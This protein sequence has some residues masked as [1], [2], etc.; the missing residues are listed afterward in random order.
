MA[1]Q[2]E[3]WAFS[4]SRLAFNTGKPGRAKSLVIKVRHG[5]KNSKESIGPF[6]LALVV[7]ECFEK[8][9]DK[10]LDE[11][12]FKNTPRATSVQTF[13]REIHAH[14]DTRE[15][16]YIARL[17][18]DEN[19]RIRYFTLKNK[20]N[21]L[22]E[23]KPLS[24]MNR[25]FKK[26]MFYSEFV[27]GERQSTRKIQRGHIRDT[28]TKLLKESSKI[29]RN[30]IPSS[31][32]DI[33]LLQNLDGVLR[34]EEA[35]LSTSNLESRVEPEFEESIRKIRQL[36]EGGMTMAAATDFFHELNI[37]WPKMMT[38]LTEHIVTPKAITQLDTGI[39]NGAL[40][41]VISPALLAS[42]T[43][44]DTFLRTLI[45]LF[46]DKVSTSTFNNDPI[47]PADAI[48][49]SYRI[50]DAI[51]GSPSWEH[52]SMVLVKVHIYPCV[53]RQG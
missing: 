44:V 15:S 5:T 18:K 39:Y 25:H 23:L 47:L 1:E 24:S 22:C 16:G 3:D 8:D 29:W 30:Q 35:A 38:L 50:A 46:C 26:C 17:I 45:L 40:S 49:H 51:V 11:H 37:F 13:D 20:Q 12:D 2:Q 21:G 4:C 9:D 6:H 43:I 53:R 48:L 41:M 52:Q 28:I 33:K 7:G 27:V 31:G 32:G 42:S 19:E 36:G 34:A 10:I 14:I